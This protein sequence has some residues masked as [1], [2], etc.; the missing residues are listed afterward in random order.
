VSDPFQDRILKVLADVYP[1]EL[2]FSELYEKLGRP[3][4]S[5][6]SKHLHILVEQN[7]VIRTEISYKYVTYTLNF[8]EYSR[9]KKR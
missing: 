4:R 7:L 8:E 6:F 9:M 5:V 2:R 1:M 3:S